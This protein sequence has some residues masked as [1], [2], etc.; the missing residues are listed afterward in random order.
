MAYK[1]LHARGYRNIAVL[2]EGIPGWVE[3]GFPT[4]GTQAEGP[5]PP[6]HP[7][8]PYLVEARPDAPPAAGAP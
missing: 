4:E 7:G 5:F 8:T 2:D 1:S 6:H 3:Q